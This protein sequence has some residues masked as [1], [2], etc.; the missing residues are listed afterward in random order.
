MRLT[1]PEI[2]GFSNFLF[3]TA[4]SMTRHR[5]LAAR[6]L[7][8]ALA[9]ATMAQTTETIH[10]TVG[11][12]DRT[13]VVHVPS[14]ISH[15]PVVFFIH[16]YG[17]SGKEFEAYTQADKVADREKFIA[18]YPSALGG[19]WSLDDTTSNPFL[20]QLLDTVDARY[21]IDRSR[22]YCTG[23]SQGAFIS[24]WVGYAHPEVFAAVAPVSGHI[25]TAPP[26]LPRPVPL[27]LTFGTNDVS[28]VASFMDDVETWLKLDSCS[29]TSRR[30]QRPYPADNPNST[31][32]RITYDCAQGSKVVIDSVVGG[33]HEWSLDTTTK[34]NTSEEVWAFLKR[35]HLA[36]TSVR[37]HAPRSSPAP[38]AIYR[39]GVVHLYD[40]E[41]FRSVQVR[42]T[43]GNLVA[44]AP[45]VEETFEF[46]NQPRGIYLVTS[47]GTGAPA[48][49]LTVP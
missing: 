26:P 39:S 6:L 18:I 36:T 9:T 22:V 28:D 46:R 21:Q 12:T 1:T 5:S 35:Y 45:V 34:V 41:K 10:A 17:G 30:E 14:G 38:K 7:P 37:N 15:P 19:S 32:S 43:R 29:P 31:V 23:F 24:F 33:S 13:G 42:N 49:K 20:L 44:N 16:G 2:R 47:Q 48:L 4:C 27:F 11:T 25:P 3:R 40:I 8:L